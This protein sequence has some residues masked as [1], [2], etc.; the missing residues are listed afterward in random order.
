MKNN[1]VRTS[2]RENERNMQNLQQLVLGDSS[3]MERAS[4]RASDPD[5]EAA[6]KIVMQKK[7]QDAMLLEEENS[8]IA[9]ELTMN[10]LNQHP[11]QDNLFSKEREYDQQALEAPEAGKPPLLAPLIVRP[12][13]SESNALMRMNSCNEHTSS[14]LGKRNYNDFQKSQME[15]KELKKI[16]SAQKSQGAQ[17]GQID[18]SEAIE[19]RIRKTPARRLLKKGIQRTNSDNFGVEQVHQSGKKLINEDGSHNNDDSSNLRIGTG[20]G[21]GFNLGPGLKSDV[22]MS[23]CEGEN[24]ASADLNIQNT[25]NFQRMG[26]NGQSNQM[27]R[28]FD[29]I[30]LRQQQFSGNG[31]SFDNYNGNHSHSGY[32]I[33]QECQ[34]CNHKNGQQSQVLQQYKQTMLQNQIP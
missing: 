34:A 27:F 33:N 14:S 1:E 31:S 3:S 5:P 7:H 4:E 30:H 21:G 19:K 11:K 13:H 10:I 16:S 20:V 24:H 2:E 25:I 17:L 15:Q 8:S 18:E 26:H 28:Y 12:Q 32:D 9:N 6:A 23:S 22:V 29:N